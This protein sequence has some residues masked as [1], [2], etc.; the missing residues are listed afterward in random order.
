MNFFE[1]KKIRKIAK[2]ENIKAPDKYIKAIDETLNNLKNNQERIKI[3]PMWKYR[4]NFGIAMAVLSFIVLP[5]I[6]PEIAYAMQEV[7][8]IGNIV[9]VITIRNYFDKDGNSELEVEIPNIKNINNSQSDSNEIVNEEVN[10][11]TQRIIDSFYA[12]K[13]PENH[14]LIKVDSDV[15]ENS[16][17]WFTLRLII[18][19]TAGSSNTQY[20]YYHIDKEQ[21]KIVKLSDL[22]ANEDYKTDISE[23]IKK[24]MISRMKENKEIVYWLDEETEEWSFS[25]ITDN[26]NFYFSKDGNIVIIFDK[27]EIGPGSTG[28]PEF[29]I[30]KQIYEKYLKDSYKK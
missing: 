26:Q 5:N 23:E 16:E 27:Y 17:K 13:N 12:E 6:S 20:K 28:T 18:S 30:N 2:N 4:L 11:L 21:D 19:E 24:Q 15:I 1:D 22:F 9:K 8:I 14:I 25:T 3:R 10:K 29:E 7:P